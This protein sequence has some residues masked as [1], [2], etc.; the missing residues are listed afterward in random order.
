MTN[1]IPLATAAE[2]LGLSRRRIAQL[3]DAEGFMD[4]IGQMR[5]LSP[6]QFQKIRRAHARMRSYVKSTI[7]NR[8]G[9]KGESIE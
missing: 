7:R 6:S 8:G 2:R 5:I 9:N 4:R 3:A 1:L